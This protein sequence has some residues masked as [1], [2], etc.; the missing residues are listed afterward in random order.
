MEKHYEKGG[1]QEIHDHGDSILSGCIFL[2]NPDP[3]FGNF[4]FIID[5]LLNFL[6][7]NDN[8]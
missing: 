8:Y 3:D 1:F 4:I 7:H 5:M 2:D 6:N